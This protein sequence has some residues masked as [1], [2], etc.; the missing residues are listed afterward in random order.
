[1]T[2]LREDAPMTFEQHAFISY[3]HIDNQPLTPDQKGWVTQ[4]HATLATMLSQRLGEKARIWRDDKL[5]GNDAF[6]DEILDQ[7]AKTAMLVSVL[8]PRYL[9]SDWCTRE[10]RAFLDAAAATGGVTVNNKSRLFKVVKTPVDSAALTLPEEAQRTLGYE[11]FERAGDD[12]ELKELDPAFGEQARQQFLGKLSSLAWQMAKSLKLLAEA[13]DVTA[14]AGKTGATIRD[15]AGKGAVYIASCGRDLH[16]VREQLATDLRRHGYEVLPVQ[17]LPVTA[18]GL[19]REVRT[20]LERASLSIHLIGQ[21]AGPIPDGPDERSAVMLENDLAAAC[22]RERGLRRVIWLPDGVRGERDEQQAFIDALQSDARLQFGADL[23]RGDVEALKHAAH[24]ALQRV[25]RDAA[26][27]VQPADDGVQVV[28]LQMSEADRTAAVPLIKMLRARGVRVTIPVFVGDAAALRQANAQLTAD[29][30][31]LLLF[32]GDGDEMWKFH[33]Q[34][35][36]RKQA[37]TLQR[38]RPRRDVLLLAPPQ[39]PDKALIQALA[40]ANT[41]DASSGFDDATL[42]PLWAVLAPGGGLP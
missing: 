29:C 38:V 1:M 14:A 7:F 17:Q 39:T 26:T 5:D 33:Q 4:F 2:A 25:C 8:S 32:Y 13:A 28:H 21:S 15:D 16:A 24:A 11:F 35:D 12:G 27:K 20:L 36:L 34:N 9:K 3:A 6:S 30:D 37:A 18:D 41:I 31:V 40:E 42:A 19:S 23:L 10:L 22:S